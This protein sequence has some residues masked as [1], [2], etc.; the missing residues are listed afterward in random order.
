[1]SSGVCRIARSH[2]ELLRDLPGK[3]RVLA[4]EVPVRG[5]LLVDGAQKIK[6]ADDA[7]R[8]EVEVSLMGVG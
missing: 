1:M 3:V 4:T 6:L 5:G 7:S 2:G 8:A